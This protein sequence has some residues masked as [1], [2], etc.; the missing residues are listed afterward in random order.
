MMEAET[1]KEQNYRYQTIYPGQIDN[2][3]KHLI[4]RLLT[5]KLVNNE[6]ISGRLKSFGQFDVV[7]SDSRTGWDILLFKH[8]I[9]SV[10]G[11]LSP[12]S[13]KK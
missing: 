6:I 7:I 5:F 10:W 4:G 2:F 13:M 1:K 12:P 11:D 8:A 3:N 9:I